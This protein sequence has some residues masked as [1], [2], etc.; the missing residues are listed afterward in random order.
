MKGMKLR[1]VFTI[2]VAVMLAVLG[3]A[4]PGA[5]QKITE[6]SADQVVIGAK[7]KVEQERK[8]SVAGDRVRF[9]KVVPAD[10]KVTT[11]YRKDL[12]QAVTINPG[13]KTYFEGAL[14]E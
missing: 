5:A 11:I 10:A 1:A 3:I 12:K 9:D 4:A 7:G 13:K 8:V 14:D 6:F 2:S